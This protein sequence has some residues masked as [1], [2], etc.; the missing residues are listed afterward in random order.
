M[1]AAACLVQR[2][3]Q[4]HELHGVPCTTHAGS[5]GLPEACAALLWLLQITAWLRRLCSEV[6]PPHRAA[7]W[8]G[9]RWR[10]DGRFRPGTMFMEDTRS[11][12]HWRHACL[13]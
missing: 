10:L 3:N 5:Q 7:L 1:M 2:I 4:D 8:R 6:A 13:P 9:Q 11:A 12:L